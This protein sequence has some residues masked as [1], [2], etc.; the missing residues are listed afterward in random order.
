M[1]TDTTSNEESE[2]EQERSQRSTARKRKRSKQT[3]SFVDHWLTNKEFKD[4]LCKRVGKDNKVQ[5]YCK[6]CGR[7]FDM[8]KNRT[9]DTWPPPCIRAIPVT[10]PIQAQ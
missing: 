1:E 7:F 8:F 9:K 3:Q 4:W 10:Q 2:N 5:P 6:T